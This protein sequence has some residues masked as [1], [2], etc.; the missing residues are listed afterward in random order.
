MDHQ[1]LLGQPALIQLLNKSTKTED[2]KKAI[3]KITKECV[4]MKKT[5][6]RTI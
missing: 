6:L 4:T 2:E 3:E 5:F 1:S